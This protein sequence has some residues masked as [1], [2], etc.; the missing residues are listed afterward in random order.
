MSYEV[1]V[2]GGGI[3]GLTTAAL[4]A[5]RGFKVCLLERQSKVG[6]CVANFEHLGYEFEPTYGLYQ[7]FGAEE[8]FRRIFSELGVKEICAQLASPS[9]MT[10]ISS[11]T[12]I[13]ISLPSVSFAESLRAAFPECAD[14]AIAFYQNVAH[15]AVKQPNDRLAPLLNDCGLRFR[16]F[17]SAQLEM[18][19]Q[20]TS[21]ACSIQRAN[22]LLN[23]PGQFWTIEGG[24][25]HVANL[26]ADSIKRSGGIVRLNTP[27]LR[28]AYQTDGN[29]IGVDLLTGERVIASKAIVSNLTMW[30]TFGKLVG[31]SRTPRH[32]TERLRKLNSP[33]A[34]LVF[35]G[36]DKDK[37]LRLPSTRILA[38]NH[39]VP[40]GEAIDA[41]EKPFFF[42]CGGPGLKAPDGKVPATVTTLV[43]AEEWFSYQEDHAAHEQQDQRMLER[44]W[45]R[46][47]AQVPELGD[48]EVIESAT[49]QSYYET[50]RRRFG[51]IGYAGMSPGEITN[52][53][54][55]PF[56]NLFVVSDTNSVD[57]G[58]AGVAE[59]AWTVSQTIA[60]VG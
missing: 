36:I 56:Q 22:T 8:I 59:R 2:V 4:L 26:L 6:G 21:D 46:L 51:M 35:L 38:V 29:P 19:L 47:H 10:R 1:V 30:D 52:T 44:V 48:V 32:I 55:A 50:V 23:S 34:Y 14:A 53:L 17:V 20:S 18:F 11:Q 33:G 40:K 42:S 45:R 49:P 31:L 27:V 37:A 58:I 9:Y 16:D 39:D 28:L 43:P 7:G 12:D 3:G 13:R 24:A 57:F 5:H 25:Q 54:P 41:D 60:P 15:Y